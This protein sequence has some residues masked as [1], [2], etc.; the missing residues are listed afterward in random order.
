MYIRRGRHLAVTLAMSC[1]FA[2]LTGQRGVG[3]DSGTSLGFSSGRS[4][5]PHPAVSYPRGWTGSSVNVRSRPGLSPASF[6]IGPSGSVLRSVVQVAI[7][8]SLAGSASP[9]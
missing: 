3:S 7:V 9:G 6:Q 4:N 8:K 1:C 5:G 2:A